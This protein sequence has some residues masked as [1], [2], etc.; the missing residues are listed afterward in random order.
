MGLLRAHWELG[1][2]IWGPYWIY[3]LLLENKLFFSRP[4]FFFDSDRRKIG[5]NLNIWPK[6]DKNPKLLI[7]E[8]SKPTRSAGHDARYVIDMSRPPQCVILI[9]RYIFLVQTKILATSSSIE[10]ELVF[11]RRW[12]NRLIKKLELVKYCWMKLVC[13]NGPNHPAKYGCLGVR[14]YKVGFSL[15]NRVSLIFKG[16]GGFSLLIPW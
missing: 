15:V 16:G 4:L 11:D 6:S 3:I 7:T 14:S 1:V 9:Q 2:H 8:N 5:Q 12:T 10:D 13:H